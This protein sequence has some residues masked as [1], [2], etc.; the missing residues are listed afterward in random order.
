MLEAQTLSVERLALAARRISE[1]LE[2]IAD[3]TYEQV[4]TFNGNPLTM[5]AARAVLTEILDASAYEHFARLWKQ[6]DAEVTAIIAEHDLDAYTIGFGAKG[7]VTF[8]A[9]QVRNYRDY[10][11]LDDLF[12][13]AH[14]LFQHNGGV[15]LPP[16]GKSEQWTM[17]VQHTGDDI[18]RLVSNFERFARALR[19]SE[20]GPLQHHGAADDARGRSGSVYVRQ[21][22]RAGGSAR[23][24]ITT[25]RQQQAARCCQGRQDA[26][27]TTHAPSGSAPAPRRPPCKAA[28]S[29]A[30]TNPLPSMV[31]R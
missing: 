8:S 11:T 28:G 23:S 9:Q 26:I 12:S 21:N 6:A 31:L 14:W 10:L 22:R 27:S 19:A 16:W 5:A 20:I 15:F 13:H 3:G 18:A 7:C 25:A 2:R 24:T 4:G 29:L 17:S 30:V 1:T